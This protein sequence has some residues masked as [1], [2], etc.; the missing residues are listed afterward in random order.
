MAAEASWCCGG[1]HFET[2]TICDQFLKPETLIIRYSWAQVVPGALA[3]GAALH[4][5][6]GDAVVGH[7]GLRAGGLPA[8]GLRGDRRR[9]RVPL[10]HRRCAPPPS[11]INNLSKEFLIG[12]GTIQLWQ[13]LA[14]CTRPQSQAQLRHHG[15][16]P[17]MGSK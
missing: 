8:A 13:S 6:V 4:L 10:R 12:Q 5:C 15:S 9:D 3:G 17:L 16:P 2:C 11:A 7:R 1:V 14:T